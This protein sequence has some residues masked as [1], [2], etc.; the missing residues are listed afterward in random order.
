MFG[1]KLDRSVAIFAFAP[2]SALNKH[3]LVFPAEGFA[4][5]QLCK[6]ALPTHC[7]VS[8]LL[9]RMSEADQDFCCFVSIVASAVAFASLHAPCDFSKMR[10]LP[11]VLRSS[12]PLACLSRGL[13]FVE[14]RLHSLAIVNQCLLGCVALCQVGR[15]CGKRHGVTTALWKL[16]I[17]LAP[18]PPPV[19]M[20][21]II[22]SGFSTTHMLLCHQKKTGKCSWVKTHC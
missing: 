21:G 8:A 2:L 16:K 3:L 19:R 11:L 6:L 9:R 14:F 15:D 17:C 12:E 20:L 10:A 5:L 13:G 4:L 22:D 1:F 7:V 18:W